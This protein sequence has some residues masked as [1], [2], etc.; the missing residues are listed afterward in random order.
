MTN[1]QTLQAEATRI[2]DKSDL[3]GF[4]HQS[5]SFDIQ[6]LITKAFKAGQQDMLER[7]KGVIPKEKICL[8]TKRR[9]DDDFESTVCA[10]CHGG[11]DECDCSG[12]NTCREET[13][14]ALDNLKN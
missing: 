13:L 5:T 6:E 7:V 14:K 9:F 10:E 12:F 3:I 4:A 8:E 2:L 11:P 1:L